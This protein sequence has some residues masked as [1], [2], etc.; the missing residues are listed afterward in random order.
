MSFL[1]SSDHEPHEHEA[2]LTAVQTVR[3][4]DMANVRE[5]REVR[6]G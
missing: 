3:L 4:R 5:P 2:A 1:K 6:G